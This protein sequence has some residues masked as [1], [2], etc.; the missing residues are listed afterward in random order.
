MNF[1]E[2]IVIISLLKNLLKKI[3]A[4]KQTNFYQFSKV[5]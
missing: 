4:N 1:I 3:R 2:V 5:L